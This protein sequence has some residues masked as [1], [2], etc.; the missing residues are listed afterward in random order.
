MV[1]TESRRRN[2]FHENK[3]LLTNNKQTI[4]HKFFNFNSCLSWDFDNVKL[5]VVNPELLF[6]CHYQLLIYSV[7]IYYIYTYIYIMYTYI[8]I[9]IYIYKFT[10]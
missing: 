6:S 1:N 8:Y 9:Y 7:Y 5:E 4:N 10:K 2:Q 3:F